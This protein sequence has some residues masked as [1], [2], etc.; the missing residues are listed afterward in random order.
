MSGKAEIQKWVIDNDFLDPQE[1]VE[2]NYERLEELFRKDNRSPLDTILDDERSDFIDWLGNQIRPFEPPK[3]EDFIRVRA[4][5]YIRAGKV[6][7]VPSH[8]RKRK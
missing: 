2:E 3:K 6:I 8:K 7:N 1:S 4:Y 5:S